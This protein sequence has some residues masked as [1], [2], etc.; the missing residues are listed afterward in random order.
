MSSSNVEPV[1]HH[2][3]VNTSIARAFDLFITRFDAVKPREHNLLSVPI[4]ETVFDPYAGGH[5]YDIGVDGSRCQWARVLAF[6]PPSRVVFTWDIS[7]TWQIEHDLTKT[8]EVEVRF[9]AESGE[10]TR[11]ELEHRHLERHGDSWRSVA[12]GVDGEAGWPLYLARYA[13]QVETAVAS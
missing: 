5:I 10:R 4:A 8:S 13:E 11:V 2:V 9:I 3:V 1:R 7:P 12:D 6:E